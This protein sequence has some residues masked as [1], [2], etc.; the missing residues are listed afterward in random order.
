MVSWPRPTQGRALLAG[1]FAGGFPLFETGAIIRGGA[2]W[3]RRRALWATPYNPF[4]S[5]RGNNCNSPSLCFQHLEASSFLNALCSD[6]L[7][8]D[9]SIHPMRWHGDCS[10]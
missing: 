4:A 6:V 9:L 1:F 2:R 10:L 7:W 8:R 3:S 5:F